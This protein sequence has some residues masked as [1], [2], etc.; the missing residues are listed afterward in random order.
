M[1]V[2]GIVPVALLSLSFCILEHREGH[3][4]LSTEYGEPWLF[5]VMGAIILLPLASI[6]V[7]RRLM[8]PLSELS[9][10]VS[11]I[12]HG[13]SPEKAPVGGRDEVDTLAEAFNALMDEFNAVRSA[14]ESLIREVEDHKE[15]EQQIRG[16]LEEKETILKEVHHR[17]KNNMATV[18]SLLRMQSN[19]TEDQKTREILQDSHNRLNA[20]SLIHESLTVTDDENSIDI[21]NYLVDLIGGIQRSYATRQEPASFD[22]D[23]DSFLI[24]TKRATTLG[25]IVNELV[26]NS[27]KHASGKEGRI[28]V[29]IS[30]KKNREEGILTVLDN[31][32]GFPSG[33]DWQATNTLGLSLVK[34]LVE[35]QLEG[36]ITRS[37][38]KGATFTVQF[39]GLMGNGLR[40]KN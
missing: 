38:N 7:A 22:L 14:K 24:D 5:L 13:E 31:G 21:R 16:C 9:S 19:Q 30:L 8:K 1:A 3:N 2:I 26:T 20:M 39:F 34:M 36:K 4:T 15:L 37:D 29:T 35:N 10:V 40:T 23:I 12:V 28:N 11:G 33:F 6:L 17:V 18:S 27:L 32:P 25:L